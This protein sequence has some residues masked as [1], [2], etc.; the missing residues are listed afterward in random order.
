PGARHLV[1]RRPVGGPVDVRRMDV[2]LPRLAPAGLR[3]AGGAGGPVLADPMAARHAGDAGPGVD[4]ARGV[5]GGVGG[6]VRRAQARGPAPQLP[7]R[8]RV[9]AGRP[10]LAPVEG[11]SPARLA[12]VA[13][14]ARPALS[15]SRTFPPPA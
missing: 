7:D 8:P 13:R 2:L 14:P 12:L 10:G 3:H 11:L 15:R 4:G 5:R 6:A 9:P 1:P